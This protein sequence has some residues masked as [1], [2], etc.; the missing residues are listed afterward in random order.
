M[1]SVH[2][3]WSA[4]FVLLLLALA[5]CDSTE[6]PVDDR[7]VGASDAL[8]MESCESVSSA[9][10]DLAA[11][12]S[13]AEATGAVVSPGT[14]YRVTLPEGA[15]GYAVLDATLVHGDYGIFTDRHGAVLRVGAHDI[16]ELSRRHAVCGDSIDEDARIHIHEPGQPVIEFSAQ[17]PRTL[18]LLALAAASDHTP[19]GGMHHDHDGGT[20]HDH[21]AG[22]HHDHDGGAH[23]DH[24]AGM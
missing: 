15:A 21:D 11:A 23:H 4:L 6:A 3:A 9:A 13:E 1:L 2:R 10:T 24:D 16:E 17:G 5:G 20:H 22:A 18:W 12:A 14:A 7:P 8:S 19:D